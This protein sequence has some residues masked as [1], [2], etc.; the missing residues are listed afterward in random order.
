M[1]LMKLKK[2]QKIELNSSKK[3]VTKIKSGGTV[4]YTCNDI[5]YSDLKLTNVIGEK[6]RKII[7]NNNLNT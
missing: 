5:V 7:I 1:I 3:T 6:V 2:N 4:Y